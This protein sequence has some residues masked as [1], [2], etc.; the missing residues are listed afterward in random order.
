MPLESKAQFRKLHALENEGK[1]KPGTA[2]RWYHHTSSF[3][4]LPDHKRDAEKKSAGKADK[5]HGGLAD[6]KTDS[7]FDPQALAKGVKVEMEHTRYEAVAREIAR[8]HLTEDPAYYDK[9][10]KM[11]KKAAIL[12]QLAVE[13]HPTALAV[14]ETLK[15]ATV[16]R[17]EG[18]GATN[19][20]MPAHS[21]LMSP[22]NLS[23]PMQPRGFGINPL[24]QPPQAQPQPPVKPI[25]PFAPK[26]PAG[27]SS[28]VMPR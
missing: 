14:I 23:K 16:G 2:S 26:P 15:Q 25:T 27:A 3:G 6:D 19:S 10:E 7:D 12:M 1:V 18:F 17:N 8:D 13:G 9:L 20:M 21:S 28:A 24:L 11:E 4:S 5:I 22:A